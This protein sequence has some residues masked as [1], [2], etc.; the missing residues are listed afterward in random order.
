MPGTLF[1]RLAAD[2]RG[3]TAVI[4]GLALT[5]LAGSAGLAVDIASWLNATRGMQAAADQA[6]YSGAYSAGTG[7]CTNTAKTQAKGVAAAR[8]YTTGVNSTVVL[9]TCNASTSAFTVWIGQ[10]QP[11][12]FASLFLSSAPTA[13]ARATAQLASK[14]SDVCILALD[15]TNFATMQ[16][17]IDRGAPALTGDTTRNMQSGIAG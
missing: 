3:L 4:T 12:W 5:I 10:A 2:Q 1:G 9:V 13:S 6:A 11:M 16:A 15:G 14:V 17:G 7:G 8:G